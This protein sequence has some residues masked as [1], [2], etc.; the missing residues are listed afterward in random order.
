MQNNDIHSVLTRALTL[1][2]TRVTEAAAVA[3]ARLRG[4]GDEMAADLAAARAMRRELDALAVRGT[5]VIGEGEQDEA[6]TLFIGERVGAGDGPEVDIAV[7]PLEGATLCAK[8]MPNALSVLAI[9]GRG[10]LLKV[11]D[12][13]MEKI[14]VGRGYDRG[15]VDLDLSPAENLARLAEAKGVAV[16]ELTA[17]ILDRPRHFRLI[18]EV[19]AA[20]AAIRLIGDGDIA[21]VI[22]TVETQDTGVDI[23]IGIGGAPE[24]VLAAAALRCIGGQLQ[25]RLA[26]SN[27]EQRALAIALGIT[28]F[29]RKYTETDMAAGDV[30][31][32]ATGVT[33]GSLLTGVR[34]HDGLIETNS[35]MMR[36]A[37]GTVRWIVTQHTDMGKFPTT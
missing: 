34:F 12:I 3:A 7:D 23:Y 21:G 10:C 17:C 11:P 22:E 18:Q 35:V 16:S 29:G 37:T 19:R 2:A 36:G 8:A 1:E 28:D 33:D 20:G 9:A 30:I 27:D 14:A 15:I 32:A 5:I 4:R 31:F 25:A 24:G 6:P 13:Y 26:P